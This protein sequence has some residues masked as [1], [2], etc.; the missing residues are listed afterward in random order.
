MGE[1]AEMI[2]EGILCQECG[3]LIEDLIPS[4]GEELLGAPGY[5][6]ACEDCKGK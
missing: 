4:V 1:I 6:R 3:G 2:H 5:P